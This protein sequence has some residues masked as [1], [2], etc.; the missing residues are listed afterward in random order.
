MYRKKA[1]ILLEKNPAPKNKLI[2]IPINPNILVGIL[3]K[4]FVFLMFK[5]F[6]FLFFA[7][8]SNLTKKQKI[9]KFSTNEK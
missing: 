8:I 4:A 7:S 6:R 1:T 2:E 5:T 3:P 9:S